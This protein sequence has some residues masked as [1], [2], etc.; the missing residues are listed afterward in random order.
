MQTTKLKPCEMCGNNIKLTKSNYSQYYL[1]KTCSQECKNR[2]IQKRFKD[3]WVYHKKVI[4]NLSN[5]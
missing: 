1:R 2:L 3:W 4:P 5:R